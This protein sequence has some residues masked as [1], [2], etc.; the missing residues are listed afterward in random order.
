[1]P[2]VSTVFKA[3]LHEAKG[4]DFFDGSAEVVHFVMGVFLML[5]FRLVAGEFHPQFR[6]YVLVGEGG[7]GN[8]ASLLACKT[9][10]TVFPINVLRFEES[11]V[12][13][14]RPQVPSKLVK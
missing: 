10:D 13:L 1:M 11:E 6:R 14:R 4:W 9:N 8:R 2:P 5:A 12:R 3:A 7:S